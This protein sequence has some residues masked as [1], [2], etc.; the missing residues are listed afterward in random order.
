MTDRIGEEVP[1]RR[2]RYC[3]G[4]DGG[5]Q[6]K[7][8]KKDDK[9]VILFSF[10]APTRQRS[11]SGSTIVIYLPWLARHPFSQ[12]TN[13]YNF[14]DIVSSSSSDGSFIQMNCNERAEQCNQ[15]NVMKLTRRAEADTLSSVGTLYSSCLFGW[16][17]PPLTSAA[18]F[19]SDPC[20]L[21]YSPS[22][23]SSP[24]PVCPPCRPSTKLISIIFWVCP[25]P[26]SSSGCR[27]LAPWLN[28]VSVCNELRNSAKDEEAGQQW[29]R[30][31]MELRFN[32]ANYAVDRNQIRSG[33]CSRSS[34]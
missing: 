6:F 18:G 1:L 28:S 25:V 10:P 34:S 4:M 20:E 19:H 17:R 12:P 31:E 15:R 8:Q 2:D 30:A 22:S 11:Q 21:H 23:S 7:S 16:T 3:Q 24:W 14:V 26:S 5:V 33:Q 9:I 32:M 29:M 13:A 27:P